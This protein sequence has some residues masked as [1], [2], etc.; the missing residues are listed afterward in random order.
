MESVGRLAGGVAHDFNN[1]LGVILGQ[2][3]MALQQVDS[4]HPL[5]EGLQ[6]IRHAAARSAELTAQ[7]LGFAR[8]QPIEPRV[9]DLN[10]T[11][12]GMLKMLQQLIGEDIDL[13]WHPSAEVWPLKADPSQISQILVNLCVNA[14][15]AITDVGK[16]TVA[17]DTCVFDEAYCAGHRGFIPGEFV[18]LR[19]SDDGCGMDKAT[20]DMIFEPYFTTKVTGSGTGLG[21]STVYGIVKQN[22]GFI[23]VRSE[24]DEGTASTIYF[25]RHVGKIAQVQEE[26]SKVPV[27][28]GHGT[29]LVVEDEPA[30]LSLVS[31]MLEQQGCNVLAT[32]SPG[33]ALRLA[34][35]RPGG[36]DVLLT[37]VVMPEMNGRDLADRLLASWPDLKCLYMSGYT[38]DVISHRGVLDEDVSLLHKPFSMDDLLDAL[39][40]V[41]NGR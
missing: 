21:L 27:A 7:L 28:Q 1:M 30:I 23:K 15:D 6:Q 16:V 40:R 35:E 41:L 18:M 31:M 4:S 24:P 14:R 33:E 19:V 11:V 3:E 37:D 12:D 32:R 38:D 26:P 22:N 39:R 17:T 10:E 25:P 13:S 5:F 36:I 8:K 34:E 29:V 20:L 9:L 2:T